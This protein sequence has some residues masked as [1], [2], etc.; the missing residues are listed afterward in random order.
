MLLTPKNSFWIDTS[1]VCRFRITVTALA[2]RGNFVP[3][4]PLVLNFIFF[5][6]QVL[7]FKKEL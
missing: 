3:V 5:T 7:I 6:P 1:T 2:A 4:F